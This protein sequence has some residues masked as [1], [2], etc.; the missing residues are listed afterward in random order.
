MSNCFVVMPFRPELQYMYLSLKE[1]IETTFPGV[2]CERG[3]DSIL[4]RPIL[5]KIA[6]YIKKAD[7]VIADCTGRN[8]NVFTS[9]EWL[10]P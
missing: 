4:T 9:W 2:F 7:I 1:H 5:E 6:A 3:D 8:A 10:T